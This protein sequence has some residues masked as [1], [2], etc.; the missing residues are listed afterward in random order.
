MPQIVIIIDELADLML[1][2]AK[3]VES[4]IVRIAQKA[5]AAGMYLVIATQ[6]PSADVITGIMKA[7]IPSRIAFAV[8]S[9]TDSRI[10]L[11]EN[12]A[13]KLVGKGDMLYAPLGAGKPTRV[14]G[15]FITDEEA[16]EVAEF[17]KTSSDADYSDEI[18]KEIEQ[19]VT[20]G[21][22]GKDSDGDQLAMELDGDPLLPDAV[23]VVLDTG[24]ASTSMLQ[25]RL[26]LGYAHA[27]RIVDELEEKGIVGPFEGSKARQVLIT[28]DQWD[29]MVGLNPKAKPP[30][31]QTAIPDDDVPF[32]ED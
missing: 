21:K 31:E 22:N 26:K 2:A 20:G 1:V 23:E 8:A 17:V 27:A 6:R 30:E 19:N 4:S 25:R 14:Q 28:R 12:G 10:I 7:N 32:D 11:D 3:E 16:E 15:C 24:Q 5:R 18:L 9:A 13:E 29:T